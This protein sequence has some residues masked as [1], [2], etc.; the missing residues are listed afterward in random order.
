MVND[1]RREGGTLRDKLQRSISSLE[2]GEIE[3]FDLF[4]TS[5]R[6]SHHKEPR[7]RVSSP[8]LA[9]PDIEMQRPAA[10]K[11]GTTSRQPTPSRAP[12]AESGTEPDPDPASATASPTPSVAPGQAKSITP[13]AAPAANRAAPP[14]AEA[15]AEPSGPSSDVP[16]SSIAGAG[17]DPDRKSEAASYAKLVA[18]FLRTEFES[19]KKRVARRLDAA[20]KSDDAKTRGFAERAIERIKSEGQGDAFEAALSGEESQDGAAP[21]P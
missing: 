9:V 10:R 20:R 4:K 8:Q 3:E 11:E 7:R 2:L 14:A 16:S 15:A 17:E 6:T 13:S 12:K 18:T 5:T 1:A 19:T 21:S